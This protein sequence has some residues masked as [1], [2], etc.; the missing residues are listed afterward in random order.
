MIALIPACFE[1]RAAHAPKHDRAVTLRSARSARLEGRSALTITSFP[2]CFQTRAAHAPHAS[3]LV[4]HTLLSMTGHC[5]PEERTKCASRRALRAN[6][7]FDSSLLRDAC[8]ARS[9]CFETRAAHAPQ[10]DRKRTLLCMIRLRFG[11][12]WLL[13]RLY[14][15]SFGL[16]D[17]WRYVR[18]LF[19][20][21]RHRQP[22]SNGANLQNLIRKQFRE[23]SRHRP[24]R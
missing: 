14:A 8:C 16:R 20:I 11:D 22:N 3:R 9:S 10:H 4:L 23:W 15:T 24:H 13:S 19:A 5:H 21:F 1:T 18:C 6:D 2:A 12:A 17:A 7:R